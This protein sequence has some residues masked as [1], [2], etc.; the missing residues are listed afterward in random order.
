MKHK[1]HIIP[2]HMGGSNDPS[3]I[4]E[5]TVEEHIEVLKEK[6][7]KL[8]GDKN[9]MF[10]KTISPEH[11]LA[12]S[13][14]NKGKIISDETRQRMSLA[15]SG[16][17]HTDETNKKISDKAKERHN[18]GV[19]DYEKLRLSRIGFKQP[20]SQKQAVSKAL[21][22]DWQITSPTGHKQTIKNL[23]QFC[24][25]NKLD[26]GNLSR[27]SYKGWKCKKVVI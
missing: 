27:G 12:I 14:A 26:Q 7:K 5:L 1:H 3:N 19:Y 21:S 9:P 16:R 2:K 17:K 8:I 20:E 13:K 24:R 4:A 23:R 25:D 10:G 22:K 11:K 6:G 18:N 15:S